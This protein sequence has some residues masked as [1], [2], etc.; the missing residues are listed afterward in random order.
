MHSR[1]VK[2]KFFNFDS[3]A[4]D[5]FGANIELTDQFAR[6]FGIY[7]QGQIGKLDYRIALNKPFAAGGLAI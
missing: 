6:Q 7:M 3:S 5:T 1:F 2:H 4:P